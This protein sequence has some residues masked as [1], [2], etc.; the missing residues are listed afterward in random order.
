VITSEE[1]ETYWWSTAIHMVNN[2]IKEPRYI[3]AATLTLHTQPERNACAATGGNQIT[4]TTVMFSARFERWSVGYRTMKNCR[5][6]EASRNRIYRIAF[7]RHAA[8]YGHYHRSDR[9]RFSA[10]RGMA[11]ARC[12]A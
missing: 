1:R 2:A 10:L 8:F 11:S 6:I 7:S 4:K 9:I 3:K 12:C 5:F